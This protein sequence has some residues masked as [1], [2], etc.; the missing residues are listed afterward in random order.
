[1]TYEL[2]NLPFSAKVLFSSYLI[3][4]AIGYFVAM[5]QILFTHGLAD[6]K[7][8]LS[9]E[10]IV[11]SY[12]GNRSGSKLEIMLNGPMKP[13]APPQ[14]R[15]QLIQWARDGA[16]KNVYEKIIKPIVEKRCVM[17]H[18]ANSSLPDFHRYEE[19]KAQ[20]ETDTGATIQSLVRVSHIHL[21]GISF[22]FMFV[23]IIFCFASGVP[24]YLKAIAVAMPFIFQMT[25]I[26]S[27]WLTKLSPHFAW[28]VVAGGAGMAMSFVFMWIV[29]MYE[30]WI[31]PL[32]DR[33]GT[34]RTESYSRYLRPR[35]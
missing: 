22:I 28:L 20:A 21:F 24:E 32:R 8:G 3:I 6:G 35:H 4:I 16:P 19:L 34:I 2:R 5:L 15:F 13:Y 23:G 17:C 18:N 9:I 7:F 27:W 26:A 25:D 11:Y 31:V 30:M 1:M 14:E 29:S 33:S 10:D 12:Y